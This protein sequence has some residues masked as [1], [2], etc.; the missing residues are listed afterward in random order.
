[1]GNISE[2]QY[3]FHPGNSTIHSLFCLRMLKK[4]TEFGTGV[5]CG[6][7]GPGKVYDRVP[8][9]LIWYSLRRRGVPEAYI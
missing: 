6:V 8:R 1:M 4:N 3:G 5:A 7:C 9:E 2:R